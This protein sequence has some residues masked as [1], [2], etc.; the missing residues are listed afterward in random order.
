MVSDLLNFNHGDITWNLESIF[1]VD[2]LNSSVPTAPSTI[3]SVTG[4]V[5]GED[6]RDLKS[7]LQGIVQDILATD[8]FHWNLTSNGDFTV[9]SV[10]HL[11][12]NA[13][14]LAWP[15]PTIKLLD[16]IWK[17]NI[18]AKIKIFSWR[19]LINRL[20]LKV[21]LVNRGVSNRTSIDCPF[22]SNHPESLDHLFYQCHVTKAVWNRIYM[23]FGNDVNLSHEE[24]KALG[25]FKKR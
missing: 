23:W 21:Q 22:C 24:F 19:F 6:F 13:K 15:T 14:D 12:S 4:T 3:L 11:V 25:V 2:V 18:P 10:S 7:I 16:V 1:G 20:P 9:S 5:I 17:T 8:D